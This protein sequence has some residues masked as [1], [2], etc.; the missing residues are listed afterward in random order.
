MDVKKENGLL[1][2]LGIGFS[3]LGIFLLVAKQTGFINNDNGTIVSIDYSTRSNIIETVSASGKIQPEVEIKI[4]PDVSGEIVEL[5]IKEGQ[6]VIKGE[7]LVRIK[8]DTYL[9]MLQ[10]SEAALN[11]A[12]ASLS[13]SK[14]RLVES[15]QILKE[16]KP[17]LKKEL[18]LQLNLSK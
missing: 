1:K 3:V 9:S 5:P 4:S 7:L 6:E 15:E 11:S 10:R 8:P 17:F 12:K 16:I 2:F 18:F 13:M 14:A